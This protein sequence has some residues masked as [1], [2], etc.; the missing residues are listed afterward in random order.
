M[1]WK[2]L[3]PFFFP[4]IYLRISTRKDSWQAL[5]FSCQT[6]QRTIFPPNPIFFRNFVLSP[7]LDLQ[8]SWGRFQVETFVPI[9]FLQIW[10]WEHFRNY[11]PVPR[12]L[13]SYKTSM[14]SPQGLPLS[15]LWNKVAVSSN[16]FFARCQ[17]IQLI[18]QLDLIL[19][20]RVVSLHCSL[21]QKASLFLVTKIPLG[22]RNNFLLLLV[23]FLLIFRLVFNMSMRLKPITPIGLPTNLVV[24]KVSWDISLPQLC[25]LWW[26]L[27]P[28]KRKISSRY[29]YQA[30]KSPS[31]PLPEADCLPQVQV[32]VVRHQR[33]CQEFWGEWCPTSGCSTY[34]SG[35]FNFEAPFKSQTFKHQEKEEC[36]NPLQ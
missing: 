29:Q 36:E 17:M 25:L 35:R 14:P 1:N 9:A 16:S 28:L 24:T 12:V 23:L 21:P 11:A 7:T 22:L 13:S 2:P 3:F 15:Q 4:T 33:T 27:Q 26:L 6:S 19:L 18:G 34:L 8:R 31:L 5:P 20:W 30:L 10:L 32:V